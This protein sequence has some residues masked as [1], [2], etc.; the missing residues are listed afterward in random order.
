MNTQKIANFH[1]K[2]L[3]PSFTQLLIKFSQIN[4][5]RVDCKTLLFESWENSEY[6]AIIDI[7]TVTFFKLMSN[8]YLS[9]QFV[10]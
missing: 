2:P 10:P 5:L 1:Q 3:C 7:I 4:F 8:F 9:Y 6:F